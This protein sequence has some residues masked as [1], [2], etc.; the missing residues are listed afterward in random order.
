M[1]ETLKRLFIFLGTYKEQYDLLLIFYKKK[2]VK[3]NIIF[4]KKKG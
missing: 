3:K 1:N 4:G 2:H